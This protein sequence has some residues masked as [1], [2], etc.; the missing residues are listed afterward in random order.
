M[1]TMNSGLGGPAGYG[2]NVYSTTPKD[3]GNTDDGSV[4]VD[5][6]SVFGA[7]GI[8]FFGT[9]YTS[10]YVNSNGNISFGSPLTDYQTSNLA[11]ETTPLIAPFFGDVNVNAGG[12]IYW[13]LDP[14]NGAVTITWDG[15]APYS[16]SGNNSFQVVL[17]ETTGG[18]FGVE[19]IY[20]DIQWTTGYSQVAQAGI[21]DGGGND[22][23]LS[24]SGNATT[25]A[26]YDTYDFGTN[27]PD[28]TTDFYFVDGV[29]VSSDGVVTGT[30]GADTIDT[31]YTGDLEGDVIDGGDGTGPAGNEDVIYALDGD[32]TVDAGDGDDTI[33]GGAGNDTL[34]GGDGDDLIYGDSPPQPGIWTYEVWNYNFGSSSGQAFD[35]E[36]GTLIE[37]GTT[38][39]FDST[40][41]VNDARGTSGDPNDFAVIYTSTLV[42]SDT[43]VF[44]FST[45][46]DDGSTIRIFDSGGTPLT[47]TNTGGSTATFMDNDYHQAPTTRSGEVSLV[48]GE[49]Y[50][51]EVRHWENAGGQVISGTVTPPGGPTEDLADSAMIVGPEVAAGDDVIDG[52]A[53]SDT[54]YG[55]GGDDIITLGAGDSAWGGDGDDL[56]LL[57]PVEALG[58]PSAVINI[59]G[60]EGDEDEG[61]TLDFVGLIDWGTISYTDAE[62]GSATLADGTTVT[63]ADIEN[64]IICFTHN[65]LI[66]TPFGERPIQDLHPGDFVLTRDRGP[67]PMR[68]IGK[69]TVPG[70]GRIAPIRFA[71]GAFGNDAP[72]FVSPQ[73]RM[74]HRSGVANLYFDT[75][76]VMVPAKHLENGTSVRQIEV[77]QVTYYHMLFDR[78][79]V[80]W[81]NGALSESFHPGA[82][83]LTAIAPQ[84]REE[85]FTLFPELRV[86][87]NDY[88]AT[89]RRVLR[90]FEARL[91]PA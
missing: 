65:T 58:G 63:F 77:P 3:A 79:E 52:G 12:E 1:A 29:P 38:P 8:N 48:A 83:G 53:G 21:T 41:L 46:S 67:Q 30:S 40:T 5:I 13:D 26:G 37:T 39:D 72:L 73:H 82:E 31:G 59:V 89:A 75:P 6:T 22:L 33:Y 34:F 10:L 61:D 88:G 76:E 68:W 11:A 28:G 20:E 80:V 49:S 43:G 70:R 17:S 81:A 18:N 45:T 60:N 36:S 44:T 27:D 14:S 51:I 66:R 2:E 50:T 74:L 90:Q 62:N 23:I 47:W 91:V 57:D 56:F 85:L 7:G 87:P 9:D 71:A 55:G 15:V 78:H 19:F 64:I 69:R 35:A 4:E 84:A 42:A 16:G 24:G 25:M 86:N 54:L 32:D